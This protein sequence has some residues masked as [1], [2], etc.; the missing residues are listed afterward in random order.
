MTIKEKKLAGHYL[1][2]Y[3]SDLGNRGCNDMD[4]SL[5]EEWSLEERREFVKSASEWNGDP[6]NYDPDFLHLPDFMVVAYLAD[7]LKCKNA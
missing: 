7:C 2:E 4:E 1:C 5:F 3:A 6:E